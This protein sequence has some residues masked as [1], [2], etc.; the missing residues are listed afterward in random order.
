[1]SVPIKKT[2]INHSLQIITEMSEKRSSGILHQH[3]KN[4][5]KAVPYI[6]TG[7]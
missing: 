4:M 7:T 3:K 5:A 2:H 1:M 6:C